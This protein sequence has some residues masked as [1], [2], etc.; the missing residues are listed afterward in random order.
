[1]F[2]CAEPDTAEGKT[3]TKL[4]TSWGDGQ[5]DSVRGQDEWAE[6]KR[7]LGGKKTFIVTFCSY[8]KGH[9]IYE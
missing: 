7:R 3:S 9:L 1:M 8:Q 2:F 4:C 6:K 5:F